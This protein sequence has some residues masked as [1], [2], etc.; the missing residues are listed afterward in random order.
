MLQGFF[1]GVIYLFLLLTFYQHFAA[2]DSEI[3]EAETTNPSLSATSRMPVPV[4]ESPKW[5]PNA[6]TVL[7]KPY[8][9]LEASCPQGYILANKHCHKRVRDAATMQKNKLEFKY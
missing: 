1:C 5:S 7:V 8:N 9:I 4:L 3:V 6:P 2:S